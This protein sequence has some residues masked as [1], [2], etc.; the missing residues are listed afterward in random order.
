MLHERP[1]PKSRWQ[2]SVPNHLI[3][4]VDGFAAWADPPEHIP[5]VLCKGLC[6]DECSLI[7]VTRA[8]QQQIAAAS[9]GR[10]SVT[11]EGRCSALTD[12]NRCAVY[13]DRPLICRLYGA[14]E[15]MICSHGCHTGNNT[16]LTMVEV[17]ALLRL[18]GRDGHGWTMT[19][20]SAI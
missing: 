6:W 15:G 13:T 10:L 16:Y 7:P 8:E 4:D 18:H 5:A 19:D 3:G 2:A 17:M 14:A 1:A 9:G 11:P 20:E 12:D